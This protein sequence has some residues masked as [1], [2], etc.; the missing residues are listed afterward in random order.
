MFIHR[1][2]L[3]HRPGHH[4]IHFPIPGPAHQTER[5][6]KSLTDRCPTR[7]VDVLAT[8]NL[9]A[10]ALA[11]AWAQRPEDYVDLTYP[12]YRQLIRD[13]YWTDIVDHALDAPGG[14]L[15]GHATTIASAITRA[16][17]NDPQLNDRP[18]RTS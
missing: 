1:E 8:F 6:F 11:I 3:L 13:R 17:L 9:A 7:F 2:F 12:Q 10:N 4:P 16:V 14:P 5:I 18:P 15:A